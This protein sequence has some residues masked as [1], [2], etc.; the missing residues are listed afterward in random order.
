LREIERSVIDDPV[1]AQHPL[2]A[3]GEVDPEADPHLTFVAA[4]R[5]GF[6]RAAS[7]RA[8]DPRVTAQAAAFFDRFG[9]PRRAAPLWER[10]ADATADWPRYGPR[11]ARAYAAA[12]DFGQAEAIARRSLQDAPRDAQAYRLLAME[13]LAP[14]G[15]RTE[16]MGVL[17]EGI[18]RSRERAALYTALHD[19]KLE[20]GDETGALEALSRGGD[21][22]SDDPVFQ[23]RLGSAF[24]ERGDYHRANVALDRTLAA[25]PSRAEAHYRKGLVLEKLSD[26]TG[27]REAYRRAAELEPSSAPYVA[28]RQRLEDVFARAEPGSDSA[29]RADGS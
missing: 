25:D 28:A 8:G 9:D 15:R 7:E 1:L 3:R 14:R 29:R 12:G 4:A 18:R 13:V 27:A 17:E 11:A 2:L 22:L 21:E 6:E 16:A 24:L 19:L 20:E 26:L 10:T 5:R 23:L